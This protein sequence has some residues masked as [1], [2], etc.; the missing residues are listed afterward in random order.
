MITAIAVAVAGG[1]GASARLA[2][3][4]GVARRVRAASPAALLVPGTLAVNVVGSLLLGL[5]AGLVLFHGVPSGWKTVLGTG[6]CGGFTTWST[7]VWEVMALA[8][9]GRGVALRTAAVG[10]IA[11]LLAAGAGLALAAV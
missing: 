3:D 7:L 5:L 10:V 4:R 2:L 11:P 8:G 6:F 9:T 1:A